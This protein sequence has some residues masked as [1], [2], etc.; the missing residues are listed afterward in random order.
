MQTFPRILWLPVAWRQGAQIL[1]GPVLGGPVPLGAEG[2]GGPAHQVPGAEGA[3]ELLRQ[4][5]R[6]AL[7]RV[8]MPP[9]PPEGPLDGAQLGETGPPVMEVP[10]GRLHCHTSICLIMGFPTSLPNEYQTVLDHRLLIEYCIVKAAHCFFFINNF[11]VFPPY[12][13]FPIDRLH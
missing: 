2:P 4:R 9:P 1:G 7:R 3:G 12:F 6:P 11:F 10:R 5:P 13:A 8:G